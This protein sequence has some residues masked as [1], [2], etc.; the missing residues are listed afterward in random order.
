MRL[1]SSLILAVFLTLPAAAFAQTGPAY[2]NRDC[3]ISSLSGASQTL[4]VAN[5]NRK[6]LGIYNTGANTVFVNAAG[7]T[8]AITGISSIALPPNYSLIYQPVNGAGVSNNAITIIGTSGQPVACF[9][10]R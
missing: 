1:I 8:A 3:G 7:G 5:P 2:T 4:V 10:G 9:E 6:F